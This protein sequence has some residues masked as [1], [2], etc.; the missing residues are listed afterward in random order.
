MKIVNKMR[1]FLLN[2]SH[3][4]HVRT[5]MKNKPFATFTFIEIKLHLKL[6]AN[7]NG[8]LQ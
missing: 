7:Y 8:W 5:V 4:T 1:S 6:D 3:C 2:V